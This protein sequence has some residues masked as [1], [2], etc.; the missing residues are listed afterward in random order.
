MMIP[1]KRQLN[2]IRADLIHVI[3]NHLLFDNL[4]QTLLH[5]VFLFVQLLILVIN[6]Y[7]A[8][9]LR[10]SKILNSIFNRSDKFFKQ[11]VL[12]CVFGS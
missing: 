9:I 12:E 7:Y 1:I 6:I 2:V 11:F 3:E 10:Q 8:G 4:S 5:V